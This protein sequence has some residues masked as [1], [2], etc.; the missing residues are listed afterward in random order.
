[1]GAVTDRTK[2]RLGVTDV[3]IIEMRRMLLST[4]KDLCEGKEPASARNPDAYYGVRGV[5]I[6]RPREA[7]LDDCVEEAKKV[8]VKTRERAEQLKKRA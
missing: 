1:M 6:V 3:G 2:E 7:P 8:F 5:S 4:A